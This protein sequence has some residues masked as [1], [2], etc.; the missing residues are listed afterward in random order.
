MTMAAEAEDED[1]D[2]DL[3]EK[4]Q[5]PLS[6]GCGQHTAPVGQSAAVEQPRVQ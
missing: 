1:V 3:L 5:M 4:A 6:C 2:E